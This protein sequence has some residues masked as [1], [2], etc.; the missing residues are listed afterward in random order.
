MPGLSQGDIDKIETK[1]PVTRKPVKK[2]LNEDKL[3]KIDKIFEPT[4]S[5]TP[6]VESG[7]ASEWSG[8]E[9]DDD[10]PDDAFYLPENFNELREQQVRQ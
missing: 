2:P 7:N 1:K 5:G 8:G 3:K 10:H 6:R 4:T 9:S